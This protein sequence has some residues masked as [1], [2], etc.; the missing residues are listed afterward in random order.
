MKPYHLY[1]LECADGTF[2]AGITVD[3]ARR[4]SEHN[5]SRRGAKYTRGRRPV[6]LVYT[7]KFRDRAEATRAEIQIKKLSR[8]EK[9]NLLKNKTA[10]SN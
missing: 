2:Y 5:F 1:L 4:V 9:L 6:R 10:S 8:Q 7:K 3:L